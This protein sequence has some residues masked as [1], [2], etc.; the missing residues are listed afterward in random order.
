MAT[1]RGPIYTFTYSSKFRL[2]N[3]ETPP[4]SSDRIEYEL[5]LLEPVDIRLVGIERTGEVIYRYHYEVYAKDTP[6]KD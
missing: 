6:E 5:G 1:W 4:I 2:N 3:P